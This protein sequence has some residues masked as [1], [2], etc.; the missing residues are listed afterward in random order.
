LIKLLIFLN[1]WEKKNLKSILMKTREEKDLTENNFESPG[2]QK[3]GEK[4][5]E[6]ESTEE[7]LPPKRGRGR[8]RKIEKKTFSRVGI[9]CS[10]F[11]CS[12]KN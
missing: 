12:S 9:N 6:C 8:P 7:L 1:K 10:K 2:E 5:E 3:F 4:K 11:D